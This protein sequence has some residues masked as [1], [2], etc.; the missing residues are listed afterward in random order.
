MVSS[1]GAARAAGL[2]KVNTGFGLGGICGCERKKEK[3]KEKKEK[4]S[5]RKIQI[6]KIQNKNS[7]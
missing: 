3:E 1:F 6:K 7:N 4:K 5:K 2:F